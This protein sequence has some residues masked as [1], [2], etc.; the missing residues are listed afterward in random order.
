M[1]PVIFTPPLSSACHTVAGFVT[2]SGMTV[3]PYDIA[4]YSVKC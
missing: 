1:G 2:A 3:T 4:T